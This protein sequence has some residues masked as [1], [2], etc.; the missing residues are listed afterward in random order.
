MTIRL[1]CFKAVRELLMNV[2]KYAETR[3]ATLELGLDPDDILRITVRDDGVG[4]DPAADHVGSGV[5]TLDGRL[6]MV[7]G[8]LTIESS[9]GSGTTAVVRA[10]LELRA[11][12]RTSKIW[13][14]SASR[15]QALDGSRNKLDEAIRG[16]LEIGESA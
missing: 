13:W 7:G 16:V 15:L 10:P 11:A 9:P 2:V 5:A 8:S 1:L 6:G 12:E 14:Q 4:F 3:R